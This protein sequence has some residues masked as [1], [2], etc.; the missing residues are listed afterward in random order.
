MNELTDLRC[1]AEE[2]Y[3]K[4]SA[5]SVKKLEH[6]SPHEKIVEELHIHQIELEL[7]NEELRHTQ[8]RLNSTSA[9]YF[10]LYDLAPV[11]YCSVNEEGLILEANLAVSNMFGINKDA[12]IN[13]PFTRFIM[14]E[15]LDI[16]YLYRQKLFKDNKTQTCELR[17]LKKDGAMLWG[18][19]TTSF[20]TTVDGTPVLHIAINDITARKEIE[21]KLE[22]AIHKAN[23]ANTAKSEF[24]STMSHEIRTPLNGL[25]GFSEIIE[26]AL[27]ECDGKGKISKILRYLEIVK[28]CGKNLN[29]LIDD[30]LVLSSIESGK[31]EM[32]L[33]KFPPERLIRESME[34]FNFK[35]EKRNIKLD[36]QSENLPCGVIGAKR[37]FKQIMFNL[38]GNA[39]KFTEEGSVNVKA[40]YKDEFLLIEVKDT[41][42]GIP[43][44][45]KN[46]VL[47]PFT[48]INQSSTRKYGGTGLGLA[49]VSKILET[50]GGSL[51]IKSKIGKG[52]TVSFTFPVKVDA[53]VLPDEPVKKQDI[54]IPANILI[55]EDDNV[56]SLYLKEIL[57]TLNV[58]CKIAESFVEMQ[59]ICNEGFLPD[60]ALLDISLPGADGFECRKWLIDKFPEKNITYIAETAYVLKADVKRCQD[61]GFDGFLSKPYSKKEL[62][63]IIA[64]R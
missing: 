32:L 52:T 1:R 40:D 2:I 29:E 17:I 28:T 64:K 42:I 6:L 47:K 62:L 44:N 33:V 20:A 5:K 53:D 25:L 39:I 24:L 54:K 12:L 8:D 22:A 46:E 35:S 55:V 13:Q 27:L 37:Q 36:F 41:G 14:A 45:M 4:K 61:A 43:G 10:E 48:Q 18:N 59:K 58:H 49:I 7:Q 60:I 26:D 57:Q 51:N 9:R 21:E 30:I 50:V 19:L 15:D 34:I 11:G 23:A 16:Y 31:F 56:S 3:Q 38:I 63:A